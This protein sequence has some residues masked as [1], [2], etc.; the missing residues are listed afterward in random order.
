MGDRRWGA[1]ADGM[2]LPLCI[3][4]ERLTPTGLLCS[5]QAFAIDC[6]PPAR[7][8]RVEDTG[9]RVAVPESEFAQTSIAAP[10]I[11]TVDWEERVD[12]DRLRDYRLARARRGA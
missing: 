1:G 3:W 6:N 2:V 8:L 5:V 7:T 12:Y 9:A 11:L 10:G 4:Q